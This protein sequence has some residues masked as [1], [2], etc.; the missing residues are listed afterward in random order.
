MQS[1][2]TK[3]LAG[4]KKSALSGHS[5][6]MTAFTMLKPPS[7]KR[8]VFLTQ[9][10]HAYKVCCSFIFP[11]NVKNKKNVF[12]ADSLFIS[13]AHLPISTSS[14]FISAHLGPNQYCQSF[15]QCSPPSKPNK[16]CQSFLSVPHQLS[17]SQPTTPHTRGTR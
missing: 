16:N 1:K 13:P 11:S 3:Q 10:L 15:Y 12:S 2:N 8:Y 6:T 5:Q 14:H 7:M 17:P 9:K 4:G